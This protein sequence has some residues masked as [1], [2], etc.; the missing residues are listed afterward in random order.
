MC[1]PLSVFRNCKIGNFANNEF[2]FL[3]ITKLGLD[4]F[5]IYNLGLY[6]ITGGLQL[7]QPRVKETRG[8]TRLEVL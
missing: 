4:Y 1:S 5:I 2:C 6:N 3:R 7:I 8:I